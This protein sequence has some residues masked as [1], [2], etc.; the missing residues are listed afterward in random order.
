MKTT[1][2]A[3]VKAGLISSPIQLAP[4]L[5]S[6]LSRPRKSPVLSQRL[7]VSALAVLWLF[8]LVAGAQPRWRERWLSP[9]SLSVLKPGDIVFADSGNAIQ[10]GFIIKVDPDTGEQTVIS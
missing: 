7:L 2:Q 10:G 6:T 8:P 9:A 3:H 5:V 4:N 1:E